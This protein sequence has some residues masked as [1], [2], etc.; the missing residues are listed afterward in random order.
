MRL[1]LGGIF[2]RKLVRILKALYYSEFK[3]WY[4]SM[5]L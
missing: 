3:Y 2:G 1:V 5:L 4:I